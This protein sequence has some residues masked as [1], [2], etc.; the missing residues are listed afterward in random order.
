MKNTTRFF[1]CIS[2]ILAFMAIGYSILYNF[3][4][5]TLPVSAQ[6]F[7]HSLPRQGWH[8][9]TQILFIALLFTTYFTVKQKRFL[10]TTILLVATVICHEV[11]ELA[12][13]YY[14]Q[15]PWLG[16]SHD[17]F[18]LALGCY[19]TTLFL[20]YLQQT[21]PLDKTWWSYWICLMTLYLLWLLW[22]LFHIIQPNS[23]LPVTVDNFWHMT[24]QTIASS[25]FWLI[26][27]CT[28][29]QLLGIACCFLLFRY[30]LGRYFVLPLL[31]LYFFN[32]LHY[33]AGNWLTCLL[34]DVIT[35]LTAYGVTLSL[36]PWVFASSR[37]LDAK[38]CPLTIGILTILLIGAGSYLLFKEPLDYL[39]S[40]QDQMAT[41]I[42]AS[43]II[44]G[45]L[46]IA[47]GLGLCQ[48]RNWA[49]WSTIVIATIGMIIIMA[50]GIS[51]FLLASWPIALIPIIISFG[52]LGLYALIFL[53]LFNQNA[54]AFFV[55]P[56]IKH[57]PT[58]ITL[59]AWF[60]II[61]SL[62]TVTAYIWALF[63]LPQY[64][65]ILICWTMLNSLIIFIAAIGLLKADNRA[66]WVLLIL[67]VVNTLIT[68]GF[69]FYDLDF[70]I[71]P[72]GQVSWLED[73]LP[74]LVINL[75]IFWILF[76]KSASAYFKQNQQRDTSEK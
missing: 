18:V 62:F 58:S 31:L 21:K 70:L 75:V 51:I 13:G 53:A 73:F 17:I 52:V 50:V 37:H 15:T 48:G 46:T 6:H 61:S 22:P 25:I 59:A 74:S 49:R 69:S 42:V 5:H 23:N 36:S 29:I 47:T 14:F 72:S 16:F 8:L 44:S 76:R 20:Q 19:G 12:T 35:L 57:R 4:F 7:I 71:S 34:S 56:G 54:I 9:P 1:P 28:I 60:Y 24:H 27:R 63:N 55:R 43:S 45:F 38:D 11:S 10:L 2:L 65:W 26:C 40:T 64:S 32:D 3:S 41:L 33:D 39:F 67:Y 30:R 68:W 66:R